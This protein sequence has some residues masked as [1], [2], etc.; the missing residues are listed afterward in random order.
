MILNVMRV[1]W[2]AAGSAALLF[3]ASN[4]TAQAADAKAMRGKY[5]VTAMGCS[6]CHTAGALMGQPD[7][8]RVLAGSNIGFPIPG[9]GTFYGANLTPDRDTGLGKWSEAEIATAIRTGKRPDGRILAPAM[10]WMSFSNLT[11][12]DAQSIAAYLKTLKPIRNKVAG[13]FGP[14]EKPVGFVSPVLPAEVFA[15][16]QT[17][18]DAEAPEAQPA[19]RA[20]R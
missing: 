8:K 19:K 6:D 12:S 20:K 5:L 2:L 1:V 3:G 13:P 9:L 17:P 7:M 4:N 14:D 15:S 11:V 18:R 10:P 16:L